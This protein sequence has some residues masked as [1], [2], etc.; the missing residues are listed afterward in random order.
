MDKLL[1]VSPSP[2]VRSERTTTNIMAD[3]LIALLPAGIAGV[4]FFGVN[5]FVLMALGVLSA[6]AAEALW[7]KCTKRRVTIG[8]LSAAVTG[9]LVAFN[10]PVTAPLWMP[11][12]GSVFAIIIAKQLFGGLG[13]N[14]VN[15][16]LIARA[17]LQVSWPTHMNSFYAPG[18][19][20]VAVDT[21][22]SATPLSAPEGYQVLDLFLGRIPGCIGEVSALALIIGGVYL[23]VR[24]VIN[25]RIPAAYIL[26]VAVFMGV[27]ALA[28]GTGF[29][30]VLFQLLAGGLML[31]A[32]FM[33]TDYATTPVTPKGH[34]AFGVGCGILTCVIRLW[35][36]YP[37]GVSYSI[38]LMNVATPLIDR[39]TRPR[40]FGSEVKKD[41]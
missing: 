32:F 39:Y 9:L 31:G 36:G 18:V 8:D 23:L 4:C 38:L 21:V 34:I 35:G 10:M 12:V 37:E 2:H 15:P 25:L 1:R 6:V 19:T 7:Q 5:A 27:Y 20:S 24:K 3:V 14:F 13:F 29:D 22:A 28:T 17:A 16:A 11:V 40:V 30:F 26:T 41:A 33:A